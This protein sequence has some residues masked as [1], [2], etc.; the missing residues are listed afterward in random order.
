MKNLYI[1][2]V[3]SSHIGLQAAVFFDFTYFT[4]Q[5]IH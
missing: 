3:S 1:S 2:F 5:K 4:D